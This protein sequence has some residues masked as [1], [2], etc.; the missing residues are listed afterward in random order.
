M[1]SSRWIFLSLVAMAATHPV[2]AEPKAATTSSRIQV[3]FVN[4][5]KFTDF[6][7]DAAGS[8]RGRENYLGQLKSYLVL[9]A[10]AQLPQGERLSVSIT[11]IDMAGEFE[12]W[13]GQSLTNVR[14]VKDQYPPCIDL[15]FKLIDAKG[16]VIREN[17]RQLRNLSFMR[18]ASINRQ[19]PLRHEK[20]LLDDWLRRELAGKE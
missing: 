3:A 5:E 20:N 2:S 12:P 16:S 1:K 17:T 7:A 6:K 14:V 4:P 11:N 10:G 9:Q 18:D 8:Q 13:R 19:D 15:S